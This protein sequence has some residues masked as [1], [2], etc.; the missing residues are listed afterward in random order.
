MR[1][2]IPEDITARTARFSIDDFD[3]ELPPEVRSELVAPRRPRMLGRPMKGLHRRRVIVLAVLV[4]LLVA[5]IVAIALIRHQAPT[6]TPTVL[7]TASPQPTPA[8]V[9]PVQPIQPHVS[10]PPRAQLLKLPAPRA[11]L[12]ALPEWRV[13][14]QRRLLMPYGLEVVGRLRGHS[15]DELYLPTNGNTIGDTWL[16]ENTPWVWITVPGTSAPTWVDP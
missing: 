1:Q 15:E 6:I 11:T 14:E 7:P 9:V 13:G 5:V 3:C 2:D 16:V 4:L 8:L 12:V 10:A